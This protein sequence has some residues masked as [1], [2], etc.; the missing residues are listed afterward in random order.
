MTW[1]IGI[2]F[3]VLF[4]LWS[5]CEW[6]DVTRTRERMKRVFQCQ[7]CLYGDGDGCDCT[8]KITRE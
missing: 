4:A 2:F 3:A 7:R 5:A 1:E 6:G 8:P